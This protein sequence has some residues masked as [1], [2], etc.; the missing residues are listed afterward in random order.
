MSQPRAFVGNME[1][2]VQGMEP[3]IE[4]IPQAYGHEDLDDKE[5]AK[6]DAKV[7]EGAV[8][9]PGD[10]A[11]VHEEDL[12]EGPTVTRWEEWA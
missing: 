7:R 1:N 4:P 10:E 9:R 11:M 6:V 3:V 2:P 5:E 12:P 8:Q